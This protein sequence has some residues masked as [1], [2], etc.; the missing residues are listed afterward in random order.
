MQPSDPT[1][2]FWLPICSLI[3]AALAIVVAPSVSW[4][5][6]RRQTET[7]LAV[8]QKQVIAPM[9]QKWID[10]LRDRVAEIISTAHWFY[11][12]GAD[13]AATAPDGM[14]ADDHMDEQSQKVERKL[15][16]SSIKW[17]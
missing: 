7:S 8:A 11:V 4:R 5:V 14:D 13:D 6:A 3:I 10:L 12:A 16:F 2:A 15:I 17:T 9:R 1:L